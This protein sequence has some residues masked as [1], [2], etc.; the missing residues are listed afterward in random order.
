MQCELKRIQAKN[1][2]K[3]KIK[4]VVIRQHNEEQKQAQIQV[5]Q[6]DA[7]QIKVDTDLLTDDY[8]AN[9]C[10]QPQDVVMVDP[11]DNE[12]DLSA[13]HDRS[14]YVKVPSLATRTELIDDKKPIHDNGNHQDAV[15]IF[16]PPTNLE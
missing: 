6:N 12:Q 7:N 13:I 10:N 5:A 14:N 4:Q 1:G 2:K 15:E 9:N 11:V 3:Q 16:W 8:F